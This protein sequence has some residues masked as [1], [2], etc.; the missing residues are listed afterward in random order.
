MQIRQDELISIYEDMITSIWS[1]ATAMIGEVTIS[2]LMETAIYETSSKYRFMQEMEVLPT[3]INID[4]LKISCQNE[5]V[6]DIKAGFENFITDL[7]TIVASLTGDV[8]LQTLNPEIEKI[9][10]KLK[11]EAT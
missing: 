3:G 9:K 11:K 1:K 6:Q 5:S 4:K 10:K 2:S 8:I 7:F